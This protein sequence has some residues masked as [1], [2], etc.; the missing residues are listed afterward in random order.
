[1]S[2]V[3]IAAGVIILAAAAWQI[4]AS[5]S[6]P[7]PK[8]SIYDPNPQHIWNRLYSVLL[9]RHD[10]TGALFG[11]NDLDPGPVL[12]SRHLLEPKSHRGAIRVLDEFL[13]MK[14]E[15]LIRDPVKRA[16]FIRDLWPVFDWAVT[17]VP[18]RDGDPTYDS[19]KRELQ[20][21]LA[22]ILHR[23][24]LTQQE[25]EALPDTYAQAVSAGVFPKEYD[26]L[27]PDRA[28]LPA[29]LFD[30]H[31]P[32]VPIQRTGP[33]VAEQHVLFFMGR[34]RFLIFIRL[35]GGRKATYDY[36]RALWE[37]NQPLE[38]ST[39]ASPPQTGFNPLLP[40]FPAGTQVA[41]VRQ[42]TMF[43]DQGNLRAAPLTESVQIRLYRTVAASGGPTGHMTEFN[44]TSGQQFYEIRLD[45]SLLFAGR[46]GGLREIGRDEKQLFLFNGIP[47]DQFD[48]PQTKINWSSRTPILQDCAMCHRAPGIHSLNSRAALLKPNPMQHETGNELA[49]RWWEQDGTLLW[50]ENRTEWAAMKSCWR[51]AR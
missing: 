15:N 19:E 47:F 36:L 24:A 45:R 51:Q 42:M 30:P 10:A 9:G 8:I 20:I 11:A 14:A 33:P 31:G 23:L 22:E 7:I 16:L 27:H 25:I 2:R 6:Y 26:P 37:S 38:A 32:W 12:F 43:D 17:R 48:N 4:T 21:R 34:S 1:V 3:A 44:E 5:A 13:K 29:D 18:M 40:S 35:P 50:K 46:T 41:L 39:P 49:D 28:F